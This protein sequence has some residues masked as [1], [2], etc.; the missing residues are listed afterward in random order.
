MFLVLTLQLV[1]TMTKVKN[2]QEPYSNT[3]MKKYDQ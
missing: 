2:A 1:T 3:V